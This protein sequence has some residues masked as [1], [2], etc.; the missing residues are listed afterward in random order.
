M[1]RA[2][3]ID[4]TS[5][6]ILLDNSGADVRRA[7]YRR[8]VA[9]LLAD[10]PHH[11]C[12]SSFRLGL[13]LWRA[14][15]RKCDRG[16]QRAAPRAKI[17]GSEFLAEVLT[18]VFVEVRAGQVAIHAVAFVAKELPPAGQIAQCLQRTGQLGVDDR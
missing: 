10:G 14:V 9:E 12:D 11:R 2:E 8:G 18:D 1:P 6:E 3:I 5:V 4:R 17:L 13:R 7:G 15:L 16:E